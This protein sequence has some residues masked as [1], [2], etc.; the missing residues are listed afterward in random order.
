MLREKS[1]WKPHEDLSTNAPNRDGLTR[2]SNE[3]DESQWSKGVELSSF[4]IGST[5][6]KKKK[7]WEELNE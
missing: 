6:R 7:K 4:T 5:M 2:S 1:K 3:V